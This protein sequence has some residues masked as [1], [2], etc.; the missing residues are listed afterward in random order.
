MSGIT[1]KVKFFPFR[2][3]LF[4]TSKDS[5]LLKIHRHTVRKFC[6]SIIRVVSWHLYKTINQFCLEGNFWNTIFRTRFSCLL[7]LQMKKSKASLIW[8]YRELCSDSFDTTRKKFIYKLIDWLF[9]TRTFF[10]F[11]FFCTRFSFTNI[12]D[13]Q[14]SRG[15]GRVSV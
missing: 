3:Q 5:F 6:Y 7:Y 12:H 10:C 15:R 9:C 4:L 11:L 2:W 13:S 14:D 1:N 8:L